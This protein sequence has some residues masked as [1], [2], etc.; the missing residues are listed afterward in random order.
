VNDLRT[1]GARAKKVLEEDKDHESYNSLVRC[2]DRRMRD[3]L[4]LLVED[5]LFCGTVKRFRRSVNTL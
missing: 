4:E 3:T 2:G 1:L 5:L